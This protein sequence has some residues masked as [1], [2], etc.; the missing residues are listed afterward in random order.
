[1]VYIKPKI[2]KNTCHFEVEM[3][4]KIAVDMNIEVGTDAALKEIQH[5]FL[6]GH[7][8][9]LL[10]IGDQEKIESS[11]NFKDLEDKVE[12]IHA[13]D[14]IKPPEKGE[15]PYKYTMNLIKKFK[16]EL[17][18]SQDSLSQGL[19]ALI[20]K[21]A[22]VFDTNGS[23]GPAGMMARVTQ[24]HPLVKKPPACC[25]YP[26]KSGEFPNAKFKDIAV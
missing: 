19:L 15:D 22:D 4:P 16:Y 18:G 13:P 17:E 21:R 24:L 2:I 6:E 7:D 12:I 14:T 26:S 11:E 25:Y 1:M 5:F 20:Q 9:H 10:L 3:K 8:A 23:S